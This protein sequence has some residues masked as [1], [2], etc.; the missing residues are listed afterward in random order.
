MGLRI[1]DLV[2]YNIYDKIGLNR[3]AVY[4]VCMQ[5]FVLCRKI[6]SMRATYFFL[7]LIIGALSACTP[8]MTTFTEDLYRD[9]NWKEAD[10]KKIQFYLADDL[11]LYRD[12]D[13]EGA[14]RI[15]GGEIRIR[16][17]KKVEEIRF[18]AGTP[19]VYLFQPKEG[20]FAISFEPGD[21]SRYLV[22][23]PNPKFEGRYMLL[24]SEWNR[25]RQGKVTYAGER[26]WTDSAV[27]PR[28]Q[29]DLRKTGNYQRSAR[30][31]KGRRIE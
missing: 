30:T 14:V 11:T 27:I 28:L 4:G 6:E 29:V 24:A 22:F 25:R 19:G 17:G 8:R 3:P 18:R 31:V 23:G 13:E 12:L 21:D 9:Y 7:L 20:H 16:D 5:I 10:L 26:F 1:G 15:S 2:F